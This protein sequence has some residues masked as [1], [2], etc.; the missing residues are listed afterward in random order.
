MT[1]ALVDFGERS[2]S[3]L[4]GAKKLHFFSAACINLSG[5]R[6]L[7]GDSSLPVPRHIAT[8][9]RALGGDLLL[10][11]M[12]LVREPWHAA[13]TIAVTVRPPALTAVSKPILMGL[14][15]NPHAWSVPAESARV[16]TVLSKLD[17]R[18]ES[19][20]P[21]LAVLIDEQPEMKSILESWLETKIAYP[22]SGS[23]LDRVLNV[24]RAAC[25]HSSA[26]AA[27]GDATQQL[28]NT[29]VTSAVE[30][31][32]GRLLCRLHRE[33]AGHIESAAVRDQLKSA[34]FGAAETPRSM[35]RG[36][37][38]MSY[39]SFQSRRFSDLVELLAI[40]GGFR[41]PEAA[42]D[43]R[44]HSINL[45]AMP[46]LDDVGDIWN[47]VMG[48]FGPLV[49]D[50]AESRLEHTETKPA[51][52]ATT[53][54]RASKAAALPRLPS[55]TEL[56]PR[57]L[58][59]SAIHRA[60]STIRALAIDGGKLGVTAAG[61]VSGSPLPTVT[62]GALSRDAVLARLPRLASA[63]LNGP[64]GVVVFG[65]DP[66]TRVIPG[67]DKVLCANEAGC[68]AFVEHVLA[69][70][71]SPAI[72]RHRWRFEF[73]KLSAVAGSPAQAAMAIQFVRPPAEPAVERFTLFF[74]HNAA[75]RLVVNRRGIRAVPIPQVELAAE[76]QSRLCA[77]ATA[78]SAE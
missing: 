42:W 58:D 46:A 24:C 23:E 52:A 12:G 63:M 31:G 39:L 59:T 67:A 78:S 3:A 22:A 10:T 35:A 60:A 77:L 26:A 49:A 64:G 16:E 65:L 73:A 40:E 25:R 18:D 57:E 14:A 9:F 75:R 62:V 66:S 30:L 2:I 74:G 45:N 50:T 36:M 8:P 54:P 69:S 47:F 6:M 68:R 55:P 44:W 11:T 53:P 21:A 61:A 56:S 37:V 51:A 20:T 19:L 43:P 76:I 15:A 1:N 4:T 38:L 27:E 72:P 70:N 33:V 29:L 13:E 41:I 32:S 34:A 5:C 48:R 71:V 7:R 28:L 17:T